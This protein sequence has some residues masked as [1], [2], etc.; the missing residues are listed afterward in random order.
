MPLNLQQLL[1]GSS[2]GDESFYLNR[3]PFFMAG[4]AIQR[5]PQYAP[6]N[7]T[8]AIVAPILQGLLSGGLMA[9]GRNNALNTAYDTYSS[10]PLLKMLQG[11]GAEERPDNWNPQVGQSDLM[12]ALIGQEAQKDS[13][14]KK[15]SAR[16][17]LTK[18]LMGQGMMLSPEGGVTTIPGFAEAAK[19]ISLAKD[20]SI[21]GVPKS[22]QGDFIK[23]QQGLAQ[24]TKDFK[25]VNDLFDKAKDLPR[26]KGAF[27]PGVIPGLS[28]VLPKNLK[29]QTA[30]ELDGINSTL[31]LLVQK[32]LGAEPSDKVR[33]R[34]DALMPD[35]NDTDKEVESK[36]TGYKDLLS[37]LGAATPIT[38]QFDASTIETKKPTSIVPEGAQATGR[39]TRDGRPTY[40]IN[41]VE[42]VL[43]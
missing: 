6:Q 17:D 29:S 18:M 36:R 40:I 11:Y 14:L 32:K 4:N 24:S 30:A 42:G 31:Q 25:T 22:L 38:N 5:A 27:D 41:G 34:L 16:D 37:T 19:E 43:E 33:A 35:W 39:K 28:W 26:T 7:D 21:D 20:G 12:M 1:T 8:E 15:Q 13:E 3:D 9:Y 23:E 10:S 2:L